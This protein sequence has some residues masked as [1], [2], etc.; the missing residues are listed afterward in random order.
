MKMIPLLVA[1]VM[2]AAPAHAQSVA[3]RAAVS[4]IAQAVEDRYFDVGQGREIADL[5]RAEA[6]EGLYDALTDPRDLEVALT[7]RLKP[8]DRHFTVTWR[9]PTAATPTP[10]A[11]APRELEPV[12]FEVGVARRGQGFLSVNILPGN[13]AVID[14]QMF[15]DFDTAQDPA[16][17]QADAVLQMVSGAD[18]VIFDLRDNGGGSPAMVGY[19]VSAFA[20]HGANIYNTF[21]GR[22]GETSESPRESY[23]S[24]RVD[25]PVF[26]LTSGRSGSA[27]EAFSYTLQAARRATVVGERSAGAANPGGP[28]STPSGFSIFVPY[29]SPVNPVTGGNWEG[30]GV[31]PDIEASSEQALN[32]A[33]KAALKAQ[34]SRLTGPVAVEARWTLEALEAPAIAIDPVAY[35]GQFS[36]SSIEAGDD[37]LLY[38]SGRKPAWRLQPLSADLFFS[39]DAPYRRVRFE[40]GAQGQVIA[41]E[42]LDGQTGSVRRLRRGE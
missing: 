34:E 24:P 31:A 21:K 36:G 30:T 12:P 41:I 38:R 9:A 37:G 28:V 33:W 26:V 39:E 16:R 14:M 27:A 20:P 19:L 40:R 22:D 32:V 5:L 1:A 29:G 35:V 7:R 25:V 13:V 4:Q 8:L 17:R 2:I 15:V 18:A 23:A 11:P 3:P 42:T 10:A 6:R